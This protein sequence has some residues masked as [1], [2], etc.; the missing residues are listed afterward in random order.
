[1]TKIEELLYSMQKRLE[2]EVPELR[3]IDK[4][5]GQLSEGSAEIEFPC[6]LLDIGEVTCT[7]EGGGVRMDNIGIVVTVA[8]LRGSSGEDDG[9][10]YT[11]VGWLERVDS[12]LHGFTAGGFSP[13][14]CTGIKKTVP[15]GGV[16]CYELTCGTSRETGR[17][18]G[19][20]VT[21]RNVEIEIR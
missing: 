16:E 18:A 4:E 1:M 17:R 9:D 12:A 3:Y 21:V 19:E 10:P 5:R 13:L 2:T 20:C 14:S 7:H 15:G 6:V 11:A 8:C